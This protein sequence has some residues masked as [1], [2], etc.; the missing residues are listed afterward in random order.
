MLDLAFIREHP[1]LVKD[2]ARRRK[3]AVD[4]DALLALDSELR[5]VRRQA[6]DLRAE[7]NR[8]SQAI[9]DAGPD[10][11]AREAAIARGREVATALDGLEPRERDLDA[12]LKDMLLLTPNI[13][14]ASVP[15]GESEDDNVEIKRVG[16]P[17]VF[18]FEPLDHVALLT[19][20]G[21][22]DLERAAKVPAHA[23]TSSRGMRFSSNWP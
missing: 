9:R 1:D 8:V 20:L 13:P 6:D 7:K 5:E 15:E 14:D 2:V 23:A 10:K 11:S 12:R 3:T 16:A 19:G 17:R 4:V 21:M 18:D 22:L